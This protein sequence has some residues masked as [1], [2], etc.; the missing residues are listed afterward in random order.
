VAEEDAAL[1]LNEGLDVD[2]A[3][4]GGGEVG[5]RVYGIAGV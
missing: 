3:L 5:E 2:R 1:A 4:P